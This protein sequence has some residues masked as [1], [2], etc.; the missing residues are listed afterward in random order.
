MVYKFFSRPK[1]MPASLQ[2]RNVLA[3]RLHVGV[4]VALAIVA[5]IA[6]EIN[7][8]TSH[9]NDHAALNDNSTI[10]NSS[11]RRRLGQTSSLKILTDE[12]T[13]HS[14]EDGDQTFNLTAFVPDCDGPDRGAIIG[15][16]NDSRGIL[17]ENATVGLIAIDFRYMSKIAKT[18]AEAKQLQINH[19]I[20]L[21]NHALALAEQVLNQS[22]LHDTSRP[23][24]ASEEILHDELRHL[25]AHPSTYFKAMI[26]TSFF[27]SLAGRAWISVDSYYHPAEP[28][29]FTRLNASSL[30]ELRA[31]WRA[32]NPGDSHLVSLEEFTARMIKIGLAYFIFYYAAGGQNRV[33]ERREL[34]SSQLLLHAVLAASATWECFKI[35]EE[36]NYGERMDRTGKKRRGVLPGDGA[37]GEVV[38][39][40]P[41]FKVSK[42]IL[43][44][45]VENVRSYG[46]PESV[47]G[48]DLFD[49][50]PVAT[51]DQDVG[52]EVCP[53]V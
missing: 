36:L 22:M 12:W 52:R 4:S 26:D 39:D 2:H 10:T 17:H 48:Q 6:L 30:V 51:A 37:D 8:F 5:C 49:I 33:W 43:L 53:S 44:E 14:A 28:Q 40:E 42:E 35:L 1:M 25:L 31:K 18:E 32:V 11:S 23:V 45:F 16:Y 9:I 38:L 41:E 50:A 21:Y 47:L 13:T 46:I 29:D 15:N 24:A 3:M 7:N 20:S 34:P 19:T 27:M